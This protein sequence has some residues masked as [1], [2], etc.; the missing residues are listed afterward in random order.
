MDK[1]DKQSSLI[2]EVYKKVCRAI[3]KGDELLERQ[4][5][6]LDGQKVSEVSK[7]GNTIKVC[8]G[9]RPI[10]FKIKYLGPQD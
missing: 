10:I 3:Y 1:K 9:S 4:P 7:D 8:I 2:Q 6:E 5:E